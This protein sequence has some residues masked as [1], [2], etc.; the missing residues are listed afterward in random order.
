[1]FWG[2]RLFAA[3]PQAPAYT[4]SAGDANVG[5]ADLSKLLGASVVQTASAAPP[6]PAASTRFKL[7][8]VAAPRDPSDRSGLALIS[9]DGK[10]AKAISVGRSVDEGWVLQS[11]ARRGAKL[12]AVPGGEVIELELPAMTVASRGALPPVSRSIEGAPPAAGG[13]APNGTPAVTPIGPGVAP[14]FSPGAAFGVNGP[15][16]AGSGGVRG[17]PSTVPGAPG[18][19]GVPGDNGVNPSVPLPANGNAPPA[20]YVPPEESVPTSPTNPP[21]RKPV[22]V[23]KVK[24]AT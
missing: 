14:G 18:S 6:P 12:G 1:M 15:N 22:S 21:S 23:S 11:V 9:V 24:A 3:S 7:V 4:V 20:I 2:L 16:G 10:P 13:A 5:L 19:P 8:G 17:L